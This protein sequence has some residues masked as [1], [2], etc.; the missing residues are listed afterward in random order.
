MRILVTYVAI[1]AGVVGCVVP[2]ASADT[3][4]LHGGEALSGHLLKIVDGTVTFRTTLSGQMMVAGDVVESLT[5]EDYLDVSLNGAAP[6]SGRFVVSDGLERLLL[7]DGTTSRPVDLMSV[8]RAA[9]KTEEPQASGELQ[10][11]LDTGVHWRF[12]NKDYSDLF[13]RLA[14][15][16]STE[17]G[18]FRSQ[19]LLERADPDAFP[20]W[21][22]GEAEWSLGSGETAVPMAAVEVERDTEA[23]MRFRGS[24]TLGAAKDLFENES[25]QLEGSVGVGGTITRYDASLPEDPLLYAPWR[26]AETRDS[27]NLHARLSLRYARAMFRASSF[28]ESVRLYPSLTDLGELRAQAESSWLVPFTPW[29]NLKLNL[30]LDYDSDPEFQLDRLRTT[31]GA[32]LRWNF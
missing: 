24:L 26:G 12:G 32:S 13:A 2:I 27:Q 8:T 9:R 1:L 3:L 25:S 10:A 6:V 31:V 23:A 20:R 19:F 4:V 22:R 28:E 14:L 21:L 17:E 18:A 5:T 30:L 16:R 15:S 29:L 7:R 11:S